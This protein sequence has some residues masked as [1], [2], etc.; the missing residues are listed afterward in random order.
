MPVTLKGDP[1]RLHVEFKIVT[2]DELP[3]GSVPTISNCKFEMSTGHCA[4]EIV[5]KLFVLN[6]IFCELDKAKFPTCY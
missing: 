5:K 6:V 1:I 2:E 4:V 3:D